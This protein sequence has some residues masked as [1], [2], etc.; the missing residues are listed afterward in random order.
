MTIPG[1]N[2]PETV[3]SS[4]GKRVLFICTGN[5]FRSRYAEAHFNCMCDWN[6]CSHYA[7]SAGV[8]IDPQIGPISTYSLYR[9]VERGIDAKFASPHAKRLYKGDI[10]E[11]DIA[12]CMYEKEHKPMMKLF[13]EDIENKI[14]YF[15]IPDINENS[16]NKS[17]DMVETE[18]NNLFNTI[19]DKKWSGRD[20]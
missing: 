2:P 6:K 14:V 9:M 20:R 10:E 7:V 18:V 12:L 3:Y 8:T 16:P 4:K 17:L 19:H 5:F 15:N 11:A 13:F 1:H